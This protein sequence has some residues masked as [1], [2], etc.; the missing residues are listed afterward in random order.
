MSAAA[1][2]SSQPRAI[3]K[4]TLHAHDHPVAAA[5]V[6]S[7]RAEVSRVLARVKVAAHGTP[8]EVKL[9]GV[10]T[11]M[12]EDSV[13]CVGSNLVVAWRPRCEA[14]AVRH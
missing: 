4:V 3:K 13:R 1:P 8:T 7:D 14:C 10:A 12:H 2:A 5:T 6:Y 11:D 9:R